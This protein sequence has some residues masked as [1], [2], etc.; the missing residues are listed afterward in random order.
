MKI[1]IES[2]KFENLGF[3]HE[4]SEPLFQNLDFS[5]PMNKII[6]LKASDGSGKSTLM[7]LLA[8]LQSPTIGSILINDQNIG[9]LNFEDFLPYRLNIGYSFD[10][11]GLIH[12]RSIYENLMMPL[13][14]HRILPE[15]EAKQRVEMYLSEF[16]LKEFAN[17]RP[18]H[19]PG[20]V[21]KM[22]VILR[23][24]ILHPDLLILDDPSVGLGPE[25]QENLANHILGLRAQGHL[26]HVFI[27]S[28]DEKFMSL[29]PYEVIHVEDGLL[30]HEASNQLK[31]AANL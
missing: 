8:G 12:N 10:Y 4:A 29:L 23:A 18:A 16:N 11:G 20:R 25:M 22:S 2:L 9:E 30:Y 14:Y 1:A 3:S 21:R 6:W 7:Q 19:V 17:E 31:K 5:F 27:S 15:D 26:K 13:E 28:Y 24:L